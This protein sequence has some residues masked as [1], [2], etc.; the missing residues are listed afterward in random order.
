MFPERESYGDFRDGNFHFVGEG[1]ARTPHNHDRSGP[2]SPPH[3]ES[4]ILPLLPREQLTMN[5]VRRFGAANSY[6]AHARPEFVL[7]SPRSD[8]TIKPHGIN[9]LISP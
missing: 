2:L 9:F 5:P 1:T 4:L 8:W 6:V 3:T 7:M